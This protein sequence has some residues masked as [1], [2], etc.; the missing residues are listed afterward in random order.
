M[1]PQILLLTA[2]A[3]GL[4]VA[5]FADR[6]VAVAARPKLDNGGRPLTDMEGSPLEKGCSI[7][8]D[9]LAEPIFVD[10]S[11]AEVVRAFTHEEV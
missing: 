1:N 8:M 7:G 3:T 2:T 10:E 9:G 5:I 6:I 4:P 11:L